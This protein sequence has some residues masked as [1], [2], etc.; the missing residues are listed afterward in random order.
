MNRDYTL[1]LDTLHEILNL[2]NKRWGLSGSDGGENNEEATKLIKWQSFHLICLFK[3]LLTFVIPQVTFLRRRGHKEHFT[4][5][6]GEA[7]FKAFVT[8]FRR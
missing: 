2:I 8:S 3:Q 5:L 7:A 1:R 6:P 4:K